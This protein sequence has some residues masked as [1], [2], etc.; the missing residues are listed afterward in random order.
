MLGLAARR[1]RQQSAL[2]ARALLDHGAAAA[3]APAPRQ[4]TKSLAEVAGAGSHWMSLAGL[5]EVVKVR[6]A[7]GVS[8]AVKAGN[9]VRHSAVE[10]KCGGRRSISGSRKTD[11]GLEAAAVPAGSASKL[12]FVAWYLRKLDERPLLTK[13][14]TAGAIYTG[15]D[16]CSQGLSA[17]YEDDAGPVSWDAARSARMLAVGLFMSGPLLHLWFGKVGKLIPGRDI[18]STLKKLVLGQLFFGPAF[19][20]AF[21]TLNA[22]AQ[23]ESGAQITTRLQR[24]LIPTLKNGLMYW[25]ACDFI[26]YRYIPIP[27]QVCISTVENRIFS[28]SFDDYSSWHL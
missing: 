16:L 7:A 11:A 28:T 12:S 1:G 22:Y 5:Y 8:D 3:A 14:L 4:V 10:A 6:G 20:A 23:G 17:L 19:C 15:S 25:P 21:F 13:S 9:C 18:S 2:I 26:T 27:L 24:D